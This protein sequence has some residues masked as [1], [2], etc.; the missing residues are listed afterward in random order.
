MV[1]FINSP[2]ETTHKTNDLELFNRRILIQLQL[3][4][5]EEILC[6][7]DKNTKVKSFLHLKD[8]F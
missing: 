5:F 8:L 7:K 1:E 2:S 3:C 6:H 4:N